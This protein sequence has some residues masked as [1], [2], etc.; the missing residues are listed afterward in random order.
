MS[1]VPERVALRFRVATAADVPRVVEIESGI[2]DF[3]WNAEVF[4]DCLRA[5]YAFWL[6]EHLGE[7]VGYGILSAA[8]REAHL[9]NVGI[10]RAWRRQGIGRRLVLRLIDIARWHRAQT[11]FLEVRPSNM[12]ARALYAREGF[13]E[14]G[15]RPRYYPAK[16][17]RED[18]ILMARELCV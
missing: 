6:V 11:L 17:G 9:L 13:V 15:L 3:P 12:A 10:D 2:Y 18:A 1:A 8:A 7:L 5:G 16:G 14:I 4:H